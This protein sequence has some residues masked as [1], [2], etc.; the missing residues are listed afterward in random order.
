MPRR[1]TRTALGALATLN[2]VG[3]AQ[4]TDGSVANADLAN[5]ATGTLKGR[6][7]AGTGVPEDIAIGTGLVIAAGP[8]LTCSFNERTSSITF[9]IDGGGSVITTG[10]KGFLEVPFAC[11]LD[12]WTLLADQTGSIVVDVWKDTY[13]NFPP[14]VADVITASAKP[15]I[16]SAQKGQSSTLTGWTT[17]ITAGDI[18]AFNVNSVTSI[19]KVTLSLRAIKTA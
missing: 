17:S 14:T 16:S 11:A 8:S 9:I 1:S 7:T 5:M 18:L 3:S 10:L 6:G 12:Q 15:T 4:I 13:A 19:T 2:A